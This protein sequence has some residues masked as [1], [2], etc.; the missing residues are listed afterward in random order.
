MERNL[1]NIRDAAQFLGVTPTTLRR[2]E[3]EGRLLPDVRTPGG[4]RRYDL[5]R[6]QSM[7]QHSKSRDRKTVAYARVSRHDQQEELRR[8]QDV[9]EQYC[10]AQGWTFEVVAEVGSGVSVHTKG[11]T[12]LINDIVSD[13]VGRLVVTHKDRLLRLG[14]EL[15]LT[16]CEAKHVEVVI[17]NPDHE[18][19][20]VDEL[21]HDMLEILTIFSARLYGSRSDEI[22]KLLN[23][24][25]R[26]VGE[27]VS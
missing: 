20:P 27:S 9:L 4:E 15:V 19:I 18:M 24:L 7:V 3:R 12:Q 23:S 16:I 14:V 17:L 13:R 26:A 1:V 11:L 5:S 22:Q 2:W 8:Q 25:T 21:A 10:T 6:S